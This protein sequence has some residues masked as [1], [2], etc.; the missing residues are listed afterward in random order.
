MRRSAA[1]LRTDFEAMRTCLLAGSTQD[2]RECFR[3]AGRGRARRTA[4]RAPRTPGDN[5]RSR[6]WWRLA[7][8]AAVYRAVVAV[9]GCAAPV[10]VRHAWVCLRSISRCAISPRERLPSASAMTAAMS[11]FEIAAGAGNALV[12]HELQDQAIQPTDDEARQRIVG[13]GAGRFLLFAGRAQDAFDHR[14]I[15]AYCSRASQADSGLRSA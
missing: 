8:V 6:A 12:A 3:P 10:P 14:A 4:S 11:R 15:A 1:T 5:S 2:A 9:I 7:V 13:D